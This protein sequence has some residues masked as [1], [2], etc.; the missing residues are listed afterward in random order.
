MIRTSL[1]ISRA[2]RDI[3]DWL[4]EPAHWK[5]WGQGDL[6]EVTPGWQAGASMQWAIGLPSKLAAFKEETVIGIE[7][8]FLLSTIGLIDA[9]PGQTKVEIVEAPLR[10][11]SFSDAGQGRLTQ[12]DKSLRELKRLM[13]TRPSFLVPLSAQE[14]LAAGNFPL[15]VYESV[16]LEKTPGAPGMGPG[17]AGPRCLRPPS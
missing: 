9:E 6:V 8:E 17:L 11:A 14:K 7:S 12:L 3:W 15:D 4:M 13:E 10:G 2:R 16:I 5:L 1:V